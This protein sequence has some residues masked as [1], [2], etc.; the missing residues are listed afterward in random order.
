MDFKAIWTERVTVKVYDLTG[1][2]IQ[3]LAQWDTTAGALYQARWDGRNRDGQAVANGL[4]FV[5]VHGNSAHC[6][7]KVVVLR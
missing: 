5:S 7:K 2:L 6:L 3:E 4:Y 1:E